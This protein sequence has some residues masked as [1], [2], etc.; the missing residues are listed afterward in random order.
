MVATHRGTKAAALLGLG[1]LIRSTSGFLTQANRK[2]S[3]F[4]IADANTRQ[5]V[6]KL[7]FFDKIFEESGPLGK[8]ITVGKVQVGLSCSDRSSSSIFGML[9][10]AA[11]SSST[12]KR[13][14]SKLTNEVC[15]ALLRKSDDWTG[16]CSE[17]KWFS[18]KDAGK[19]ESLCNDWSNREAAKFEKVR[20]QQCY[21][22]AT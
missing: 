9:E 10:K 7:N 16:A 4:H 5:D 6:T 13:G 19:A 2:S 12:S 11:R 18:Q 8:G 15:L 17:S 22:F 3:F 14:L 1:A 21:Y 20:V